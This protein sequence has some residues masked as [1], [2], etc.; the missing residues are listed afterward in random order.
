MVEIT[1][2]LPCKM[3]TLFLWRQVWY[4]ISKRSVGL[5][6]FQSIQGLSWQPFSVD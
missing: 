1:P 6:T 3:R 5:Q 4:F 2:V